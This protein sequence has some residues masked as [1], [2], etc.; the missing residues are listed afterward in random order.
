[1][2]LLKN[3]FTLLKDLCNLFKALY[4]FFRSAWSLHIHPCNFLKDLYN[5]LQDPWNL[6]THVFVNSR[7]T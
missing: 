5:L 6:L 2:N 4:E 7:T 3:H 1:M